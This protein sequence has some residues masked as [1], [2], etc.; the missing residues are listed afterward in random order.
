[1]APAAATG[2]CKG[3][4]AVATAVEAQQLSRVCC[5]CQRVQLLVFWQAHSR[6]CQHHMSA[7]ANCRK[8]L[9]GDGARCI[10][11]APWHRQQQ[12]GSSCS[13]GSN[14][15][16]ISGITWHVIPDSCAPL[17]LGCLLCSSCICTAFSINV[18]AMLLH[19][20]CDPTSLTCVVYALI[21]LIA[22]LGLP[23]ACIA[24]R[25]SP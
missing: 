9:P 6:S 24:T 12:L 15:V 7:R 13:S 18:V 8:A 23:M 3:S 22:Q 2:S 19:C 21:V 16:E 10:S 1:M 4:T 25:T 11:W 5:C 14:G 20:C 17:L